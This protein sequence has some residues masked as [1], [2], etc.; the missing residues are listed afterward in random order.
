MNTLTNTISA[1]L[2]ENR[3]LV[4]SQQSHSKYKENKLHPLQTKTKANQH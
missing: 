3:E 1:E 4:D 2:K